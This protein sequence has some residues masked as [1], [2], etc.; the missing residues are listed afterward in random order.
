MKPEKT[1]DMRGRTCPEPVVETGKALSD[2]DIVKLII[3][4]DNDAAVENVQRMVTSKGWSSTVEKKSDDEFIVKALRGA[5]QLS[6]AS[7]D[8]CIVCQAPESRPWVAI[9]IASSCFGRGDD[10]LGRKLMGGFVK[11]IKQLDPVPECIIFINSGVKLVIQGSE[12]VDVLKELS[13]S[14]VQILAC[15]TCLEHFKIM[16]EIAVGNVSN[17]LEIASTLVSAD[18]IVRP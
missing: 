13:E 14:G 4:V 15:G 7:E 2:N 11:T 1:L 9:L 5:S 18:R 10:E 6:T 8:E 3:I 16:D 12:V 17:M